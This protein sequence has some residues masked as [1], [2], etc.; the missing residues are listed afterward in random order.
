MAQ[1]GEIN[2][3]NN[4]FWQKQQAAAVG[5]TNSHSFKGS[6]LFS[7]AKPETVDGVT[8]AAT[9]LTA[10][11]VVAALNDFSSLPADKT[12]EFWATKGDRVYVASNHLPLYVKKRPTGLHFTSEKEPGANDVTS[13]VCVYD[14]ST[15]SFHVLNHFNHTNE[16]THHE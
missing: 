10:K 11:Q 7:T 14:Y 2:S 3:T 6:K 16:D 8:V 1:Y 9:G 12:F 4:I 13:N 5:H 15:S